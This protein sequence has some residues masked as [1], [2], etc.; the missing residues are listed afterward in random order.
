MPRVNGHGRG[1]EAVLR[2]ATPTTAA[3]EDD[4]VLVR[5][6]A[7]KDQAALSALFKRYGDPVFSLALKMVGDRGE[8]EEILQD[9]FVELWKHAPRFDAS[10]GTVV[11]WLFT[12]AR[13][14]GIDRLRRKERKVRDRSD[15]MEEAPE[16]ADD[17]L[18]A[19]SSS[20]VRRE[21][22]RRLRGQLD[23]L[24]PDQREA[25]ELAFFRGYTHR[26]IARRTG[27]P[28]GTIKA[29]I[30]R[31]MLKLRELLHESSH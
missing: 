17:S 8:A 20:L 2:R 7:N 5:Q 12:V 4:G 9:S 13:R 16:M 18:E 31:G 27:Q 23:K 26:E 15:G 25:L 1:N 22:H 6:V 10:K 14:K 29:R 21:R 3:A 28:L 24:P 11:A 19:A 30:R